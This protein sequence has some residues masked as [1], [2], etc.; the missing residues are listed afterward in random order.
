MY[1]WREITKEPKT[2][3]KPRKKLK[4]WIIDHRLWTSIT[5]R[6]K[7]YPNSCYLLSK[8]RSKEVKSENKNMKAIRTLIIGAGPAGLAMAGRMSKAGL[9]FEIIE[10]SQQI[11]NA[12]HHHY[13]R[14]HL[15]TVKQYSH[16]PFFEF[17]EDDPIYIPRQRFAEYC[18]EYAQ[19][20]DIRPHFGVEVTWIKKQTDGQWQVHTDT[21]DIYLAKRVIVATGTNRI[22][23]IPT[24]KGQE[25]FKGE[26]THSIE[27]KNPTPYKEQKTLVVGLGN[28]GGEVALDLTEKGVET[29]I[30]VRSAVNPVPRDLNGRPVQVTSK[31]LE[32]LGGVGDWLGSQVRKVYFGDL[33]KYGLETSKE[34][35]AVQLR[36]SGK[37]PL[38]DLGTI[39]LIK[40]GKIKVVK[41]IESFYDKGVR[42]VDGQSLEID[43][44]IL[45]TGYKAKVEDF[46]E[47]GEALLDKCNI[48][49]QPIGEGYHKNLFF[50][51]FDNYKLGGI[52]GTIF[53]DS[54]TILKHIMHEVSTV[55]VWL[56]V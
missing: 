19:H 29:Y 24:W 15:H 4:L 13:D 21:D 50:L 46:I 16:L 44:V 6:P 18:E 2:C 56:S 14:L 34:S 28:T 32:K 49:S 40:E 47:K 35:P 25:D 55:P 45:A 36:E 23:N 48:P 39:Q 54:E 5:F 12:W 8:M 52:L 7:K 30:S 33:S 42:L 53:T 37:T 9:S 38:I 41:D 22:P 17:S 31:Q 20:F 43:K 3:Q 51:G 10:K 27:Y 11:A 1:L 26:I